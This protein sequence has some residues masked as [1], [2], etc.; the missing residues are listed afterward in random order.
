MSDWKENRFSDFVVINPTV[1][2]KGREK[3]SFVEMKDLQDG[4]K[5]CSPNA[6]R[7]PSSGARFH[8]GDTLFARITPCLENGKICKVRGLKGGIGFGSTEFLVFRGKDKISDNNFVF[9]LSRWDEIREFAESNFEGTSGRQRVNKNCFENL[10]L[11]LPPLP[12]QTAIAE[13]LS[14]LDDKIDL[15]H[16][17]NKTLEQLAET[18]FRQWFVENKE[19]CC[20]QSFGELI[21]TTLGGEWGKENLEGEFSKQ[22]CC[23]R[24]TDIADLQT[25]LAERTPI[26]YI[27]EKKYESIHPIDG[28]LILEISGGTEDQSTGRTIYINELNRHLFPYP[29]IFS[30]FCRLIRPRKKEYSYFLYL[31]IQQLYKQDE[32]FNIENGSSGIKNLDYKY[33]LFELQFDLPKDKNEIEKVNEGVSIYFEKINR[34]KHQIK[35][36]TQLRDTLLPKLMSGEV[37]VSS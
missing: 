29:I 3:Y 17:Q 12:E 6:E 34:N 8:E 32:F 7:K 21:E 19:K 1:S 30:N 33:L 20:Q 14:S 22:V 4:N 36:L 27:K 13:V 11:N 2:L 16:R 23:I 35:T 24:G 18:L 10:I 15:L 5:F 37:R 25:G 26:R 28:D 9:Y 31:Y